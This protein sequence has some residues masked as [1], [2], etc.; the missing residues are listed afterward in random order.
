MCR[1]LGQTRAVRMPYLYS[2]HVGITDSHHSTVKTFPIQISMSRLSPILLAHQAS[3]PR[4]RQPPTILVSASARDASWPHNTASSTASQ[5]LLTKLPAHPDSRLS[6]S[7]EVVEVLR[8]GCNMWAHL[9]VI[10][11]PTRHPH[12][13]HALLTAAPITPASTRSQSSG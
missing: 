8:I 3:H 5:T 6:T 7:L 11:I 4:L 10:I 9:K 13:P 12:L 1:A 2:R